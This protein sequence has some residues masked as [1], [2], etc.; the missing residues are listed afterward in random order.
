MLVPLWPSSVP[1]WSKPSGWAHPP[2][3][4]CCGPSAQAEGPAGQHLQQCL[5]LTHGLSPPVGQSL[6]LLEGSGHPHLQQVPWT[7]T[8]ALLAGLFFVLKHVNS[9]CERDWNSAPKV[10]WELV[11]WLL[12]PCSPFQWIVIPWN[13]S[14]E[15]LLWIASVGVHISPK[16]SVWFSVRAVPTG[17]WFVCLGATR[18]WWWYQEGCFWSDSVSLT[19]VGKKF[20]TTLRNV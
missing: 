4:C 3:G 16:V 5:L 19:F 11:Y 9:S 14:I 2:L 17:A 13:E 20:R 8:K 7:P 18:W 12:L 1:V 6:L 15:S 10:S